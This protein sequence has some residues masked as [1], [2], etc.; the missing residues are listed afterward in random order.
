MTPVGLGR[1]ILDASAAVALLADAGVAG[2]WVA[3]TVR[4]ASLLA[5]ELMPFE[6]GNILR[7]QALAGALDASAAKL[8]HADLLDLPVDLYPYV[9]LGDRVWELRGNLTAYDASYVAL[10]ELVEAPIVTLDTRLAQSPGP[11]CAILSYQRDRGST[12]ASR[13]GT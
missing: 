11:R 7:R 12:H 4:G 9:A 6:V 10:A 13:W 2:T 5:P 8:A 3:E 1:V